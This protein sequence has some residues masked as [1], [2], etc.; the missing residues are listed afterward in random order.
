[1]CNQ[2]FLS[3]DHIKEILFI[4]LTSPRKKEMKENFVLKFFAN[5]MKEQK[6]KSHPMMVKTIYK[7]GDAPASRD[8]T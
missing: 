4:P 3:L 7:L 5:E 2:I 6:T 1:M 8:P